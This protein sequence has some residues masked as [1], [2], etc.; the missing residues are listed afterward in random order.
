MQPQ[1]ISDIIF[2]Q[3]I[4]ETRLSQQLL[5]AL[6]VAIYICDPK[7]YITMYNKAA[8]ELWGREPELGT[9]LWCGSWRL[10]RMD[11]TALPLDESPMAIVLKG[12]IIP[13][14]QEI[15]I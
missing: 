1:S 11:G 13:E 7:G 3:G 4:G 2:T 8:V 6:P 10:F 12:E 14:E 5:Q 15:I 9:E